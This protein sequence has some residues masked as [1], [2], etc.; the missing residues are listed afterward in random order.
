MFWSKMEAILFSKK[1][2]DKVEH[3]QQVAVASVTGVEFG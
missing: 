1:F 3:L 2:I